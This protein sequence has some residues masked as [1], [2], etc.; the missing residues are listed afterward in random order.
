MAKLSKAE[1]DRLRREGGGGNKKFLWI[2]LAIVAIVVILVVANTGGQ[3]GNTKAENLEAF[4]LAED[5]YLGD[6]N[7]PVVVV[8]FEAPTCSACRG[9]HAQFLP[10]LKADYF[11]TGKAVFYYSQ[12]H[13]GTDADFHIGTMQEC[14]LEHGGRD[15]F[16]NFTDMIYL[17]LGQYPST[18]EG[19]AK[20]NQFAAG[21]QS[22]AD[23]LRCADDAELGGR[24]SQ[25]Y[26]VG[27]DWEVTGTPTFYIFGLEGEP[28][29]VSMSQI[30]QAIDELQP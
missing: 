30:G 13:I 17:E 19:R 3:A 24:V 4:G 12:Y 29:R 20:F 2:G 22:E 5:P 14:A 8:G 7:A 15:D 11:E 25:D 21:H 23:L 28:A 6:P 16:W 10:G 26:R 27:R 18:G 1:E 9:F